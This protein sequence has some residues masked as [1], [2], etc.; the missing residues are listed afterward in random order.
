MNEVW[1]AKNFHRNVKNLK[2]K[3]K[4]K[5]QKFMKSWLM[6]GMKSWL[7]GYLYIDLPDLKLNMKVLQLSLW[8]ASFCDINFCSLLK[9]F[10]QYQR[11]WHDRVFHPY[12]WDF[13]LLNKYFNEIKLTLFLVMYSDIIIYS[14]LYFFL[15]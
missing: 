6:M 12:F 8:L 7:F 2:I 13:L 10:E 5:I 14:Y 9:L 3:K 11:I 1:K 4:K 15:T